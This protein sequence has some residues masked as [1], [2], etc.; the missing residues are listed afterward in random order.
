MTNDDRD[1]NE[2]IGGCTDQVDSD[3]LGADDTVDEDS[4]GGADSADLEAVVGLAPMVT[5]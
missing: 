4:V 5:S 2:S 3:A 1:G